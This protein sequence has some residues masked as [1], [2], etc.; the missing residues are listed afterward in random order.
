MKKVL[1]LTLLCGSFYNVGSSEY[2][3]KPEPKFTPENVIAVMESVGIA[4][5]DIVFAQARLETGN[6]TSKVFR[7]NHNLFGM[8]LARVRAT[9]A[10]GEKNSHANYKSWVHSIRDYKIWQDAVVSKYK[11]R[12][13]YLKYLSE[14]YA[15]DKKYISK[16]KQML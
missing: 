16:I 8:K 7:E 4:Y 13:A 6:F 12:R 3:R 2:I 9:N 15:Q 1:I 14:N 5:P 11:S 10:L